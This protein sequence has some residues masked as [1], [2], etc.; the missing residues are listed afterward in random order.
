M[1]LIQFG[2][3]EDGTPIE[4]VENKKMTYRTARQGK[5]GRVL[6]LV[7][8]KNLYE[9]NSEELADLLN[10]YDYTTASELYQQAMRKHFNLIE[11]EQILLRKN[12]LSASAF[13]Q[14]GMLI[15]PTSMGLMNSLE[16]QLDFTDALGNHILSYTG[17]N[18]NSFTIA[19]AVCYYECRVE[20]NRITLCNGTFTP[21][22]IGYRPFI[23]AFFPNS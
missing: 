6:H 8:Y 9:F 21:S 10:K 16:P 1:E 4:W 5:A 23:R 22:I 11:Q 18:K 7:C 19:D 12:S 13:R 3:H 15:S 2:R 14:A 17:G 20:G